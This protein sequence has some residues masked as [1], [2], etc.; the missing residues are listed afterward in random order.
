[1][2][3]GH[4]LDR[5]KMQINIDIV[6]YAILPFFLFWEFPMLVSWE[7][8]MVPWPGFDNIIAWNYWFNWYNRYVCIK[9]KNDG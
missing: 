6:W 2:A 5:Q 8:Y 4:V 7:F 9:K 1:M 3:D